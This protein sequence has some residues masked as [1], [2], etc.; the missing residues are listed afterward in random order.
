MDEATFQSEMSRSLHHSYGPNF[1]YKPTD[2][3]GTFVTAK[4]PFDCFL[5]ILGKLFGFE[6]KQLREPS[7]FAFDRVEEH[8][9]YYLNLVSANLGKAFLLINFRMD[10][11][12]KQQKKYGIKKKENFVIA[13]DIDYYDI[14]VNKY[15][16]LGKKSIPLDFILNIYRNG[17][18]GCHVIEWM[19]DK[20]MWDVSALLGLK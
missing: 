8:Q 13:I 18:I 12:E 7:G 16:L 10:A 3:I 11:D 19:P 15:R 4:R 1:F 14:I 9:L 20:K 2:Q 5:L 6:L 17:F